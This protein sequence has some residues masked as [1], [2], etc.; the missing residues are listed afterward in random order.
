MRHKSNVW[1]TVFM[2]FVTVLILLGTPGLG[3]DSEA[4][5]VF[6]N[7]AMDAIG[8]GTKTIAVGVIDGLIDAIEQ[9][10]DGQTQ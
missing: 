8:E 10:G 5:A 3:C 2:G 7:T 4:S 9:A 6:R 1:R